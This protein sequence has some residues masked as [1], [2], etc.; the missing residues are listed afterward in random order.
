MSISPTTY[1]EPKQPISGIVLEMSLPAETS[2]IINKEFPL[3]QFENLLKERNKEILDKIGQADPEQRALLEKELAAIKAKYDNLQKPYE[4]Q[5]A[6][7]AEAYK[8]LDDF[9]AGI[10]GRSN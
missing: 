4:E 7:L 10:P 6:R 2:H 8:A 3:E 9:Q 5:K 1:P